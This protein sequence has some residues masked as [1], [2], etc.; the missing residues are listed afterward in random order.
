[1][2]E[3]QIVWECDSFFWSIYGL[4]RRFQQHLFFFIMTTGVCRECLSGEGGLAKHRVTCDHTV[5]V[6]LALVSQV[7]HFLV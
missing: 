2:G 7:K 3:L 1:M 5:L 4:R 6:E